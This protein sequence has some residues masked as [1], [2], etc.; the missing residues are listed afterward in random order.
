MQQLTCLQ[1]QGS[2]YLPAFPGRE[3][4]INICRAAGELG[5]SVFAG[6][7]I[8]VTASS[9]PD[10]TAASASTCPQTAFLKQSC[11]FK[12]ARNAIRCQLGDLVI[13]LQMRLSYSKKEMVS[14]LGVWGRAGCVLWVLLASVSVNLCILSK[15]ESV[16]AQ[17][18]PAISDTAN[19][20]GP[21][22][23][24]LP[25]ATSAMFFPRLCG[26]LWR[27]VTVGMGRCLGKGLVGGL[28]LQ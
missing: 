11:G 4:S 28:C 1:N 7:E 27:G 17:I 5:M 19:F 2:W 18:S 20:S 23:F 6:A 25:D 26:R 16:F 12:W 8:R 13:V 15:H 10:D 21:H 24:Q 3:S 22:L 9:G 14:V